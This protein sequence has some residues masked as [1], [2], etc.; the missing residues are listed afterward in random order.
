MIKRYKDKI[1]DNVL[2]FD[3]EMKKYLYSLEWDGKLHILV[4]ETHERVLSQENI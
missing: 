1:V 2:V 4:P 3:E